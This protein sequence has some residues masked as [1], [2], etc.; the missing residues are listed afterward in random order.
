MNPSTSETEII[1]LQA[2]INKKDVELSAL[3]FKL[4]VSE[5]K[6]K[7]LQDSEYRLEEQLLRSKTEKKLIIGQSVLDLVCE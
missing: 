6:V 1:A 4:I 2:Q 5:N 3:H 7:M